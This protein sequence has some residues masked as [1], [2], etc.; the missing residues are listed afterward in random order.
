MKYYI[1]KNITCIGGENV[2]TKN[3][4]P[5]PLLIKIGL[6]V[7][8]VFIVVAIVFTT[9]YFTLNK[10]DSSYINQLYKYKQ[11]VDKSNDS[12]ADAIKNIDTI[13]LKNTSEIDDI[14]KV[15]SSASSD[16]YDA[17]QNLESLRAPAKYNG[18]FA[19]YKNGIHLNWK[20]FQQAKLIL[21]NP[22]SNKLHNAINDL[23]GY[24]V[25]TSK[26]YE[27]SKLRKAY[28]KLP[29]GILSMSEKINTYAFNVYKDYEEKSQSLEEYTNYFRSMDQI[30]TDFNTAKIDLNPNLSLIKANS[31]STDDVYAKIE[32]ILT[33]VENIQTS[34]TSLSVP[35]KM[36]DRHRQLDDM[37]KFYINYCTDFKAALNKYEE[38]S[39]DPSSQADVNSLFNDLETKYKNLTKQFNDYQ[40]GY[41][42]DKIKYSD[43]NNL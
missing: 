2:G 27:E 16:L 17:Y 15:V 10:E 18:Q 39:T 30:L 43:V 8:T 35:P 32:S 28:I 22:K 6:S 14:K 11:I 40:N 25:D 31:I 34:Y 12:V 13:D 23:S 36:G 4:K 21:K 7:L 9:Y 24:I 20:I 42:N 5:N 37:L 41:S 26:A 19:S 33:E 29:A 1:I 3:K 38:V